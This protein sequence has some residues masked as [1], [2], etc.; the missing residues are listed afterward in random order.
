MT[1]HSDGEHYDIWLS[2]Q[3]GNG[4]LVVRVNIGVDDDVRQTILGV[5]VA[6]LQPLLEPLEPSMELISAISPSI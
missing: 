4:H 2:Q 5:A 1:N 6:L 3:I